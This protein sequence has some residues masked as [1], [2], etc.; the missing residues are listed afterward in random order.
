MQ[1]IVSGNKI[2]LSDNYALVRHRRIR[3]FLLLVSHNED[4]PRVIDSMASWFHAE[5]VD[6]SLSAACSL[7]CRLKVRSLQMSLCL[8]ML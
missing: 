3:V 5:L 8:L 6:Y 2:L 4:Y 1:I 7:V